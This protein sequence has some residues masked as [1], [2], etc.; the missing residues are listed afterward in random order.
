MTNSEPTIELT[1]APRPEDNA[2]I[3]DVLVAHNNKVG[4][5]MDRRPL[6]IILRDGA[7]RIEGGIVGRTQW[8][9]LHVETLALPPGRRSQGL[10]TRLLQMAEDEARRRGC[11]H[12]YLT[13]LSWQAKPFYEKLGYREYGRLD[14]FPRGHQR[15]HMMKAL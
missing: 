13:T 3:V 2:A 11:H 15:H 6:T 12:V 7:G 4:V 14:D 1:D 8:G 5:P 9:W 10:G